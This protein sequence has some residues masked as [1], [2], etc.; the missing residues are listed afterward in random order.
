M[1]TAIRS[2]AAAYYEW[3]GVEGGV[4]GGGCGRHCSRLLTRDKGALRDQSAKVVRFP[5][6]RAFGKR[7]RP[8]HY[9]DFIAAQTKSYRHRKVTSITPCE[10]AATLRWVAWDAPACP[11]HLPRASGHTGGHCRRC[12]ITSRLPGRR[13]GGEVNGSDGHRALITS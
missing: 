7:A 6:P 8:F 13:R 11:R 3:T 9:H 4:Y 1:R 12:C 5:A 2:Q 10:A